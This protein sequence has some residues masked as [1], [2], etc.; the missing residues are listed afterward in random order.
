M[1]FFEDRIVY[2]SAEI[3]ALAGKQHAFASNSLDILA[4]LS[5]KDRY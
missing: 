3:S 4:S 2:T 5:F 1:V